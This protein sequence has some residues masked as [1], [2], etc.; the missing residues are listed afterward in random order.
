MNSSNSS[1]PTTPAPGPEEAARPFILV[2]LYI[3]P[4]ADS[5]SPLISAATRHPNQTF[6]VVVNPANG[7][8][9]TPL[10][11]GNYTAAL[12]ALSALANAK[13]LG[14]V[15][16]SYGQRPAPEIIADI[17][18]YR[19]W[20]PSIPISGIF[21]DESPSDEE[22][23]DYMTNLYGAARSI[24]SADATAAMEPA[25]SST[26]A[27]TSNFITVNNH[28]IFP[29]SAGY[30]DAADYL[31]PF[32]N[33]ADEWA[34][35]YVQVNLARLDEGAR[36]KSVVIAHSVQGWDDYV[37]ILDEVVEKWGFGGHFLTGVENYDGWCGG[38]EGYVKLC[39]GAGK[40]C[41]GAR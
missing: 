13:L 30:F 3:Y 9:P 10:P 36:R 33:R 38:W 37:K 24:F 1:A 17:G 41:E 4:T 19:S 11:D 15:H 31:V 5:W 25:S 22:H 40:D 16:C 12:A 39:A 7:P 26:S 29:H 34:G 23:V 6:Y 28:G 20:V 32:E 8:G 35:E 2:P 18:I 21:F 14:Y 27:S